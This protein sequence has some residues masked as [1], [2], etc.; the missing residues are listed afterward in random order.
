VKPTDDDVAARTEASSK[1]GGHLRYRPTLGDYLR[2]NA[3][4]VR[5]SPIALGFSAFVVT[6]G[7]L[8]L[9][10]N[11]I[12]GIPLTLFGLAMGSGLFIIPFVWIAV[13]RRPDLMLTDIEMTWNATGLTMASRSSE[14]KSDWSVYRGFEETDDAILLSSGVVRVFVPKQ[15]TNQEELDEFRKAL[16]SA[17]LGLRRASLARSVFA[18]GVGVLVAGAA[19]GYAFLQRTNANATMSLSGTIEGSTVVIAG[20]TNIPDGSSVVL[21]LLQLDEYDASV[22]AGAPIDSSSSEW[23]ELSS[24]KVS[25]GTF[26]AVFRVP[27]W[28][29]GRIGCY[30]YF[31]MY[32]DQPRE[33]IRRYGTDGQSMNGP[34]VV[35]TEDRGRMLRVGI[36]LDLH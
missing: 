32:P 19:P 29:A 16:K 11:Q 27:G 25:S 22:A 7:V 23:I 24:A 8:G 31:W 9:L 18:I 6:A 3:G 4:I 10:T 2:I 21:Q 35:Q 33:A 20:T 36:N 26:S 28:P 30:A 5:R 12:V 17:G 14:T 1:V 15:R 34:D 13:R